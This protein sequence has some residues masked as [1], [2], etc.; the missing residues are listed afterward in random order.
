MATLIKDASIEY[1]LWSWQEHQGVSLS[2]VRA[3]DGATDS[4]VKII[5]IYS[6]WLCNLCL[7]AGTDIFECLSGPIESNQLFS[8]NLT[9]NAY[10]NRYVSIPMTAMLSLFEHTGCYLKVLNVDSEGIPPTA[11]CL[12]DLLQATPSLEWLSSVFNL[13]WCDKDTTLM[14]YYLLYNAC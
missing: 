1:P 13:K 14:V 11:E 2:K 10:L 3:V 9:A 5:T 7:N 4:V 6:D 8:L 12:N